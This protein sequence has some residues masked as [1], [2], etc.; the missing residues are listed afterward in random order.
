LVPQVPKA[1]PESQALKVPARSVLP[2]RLDLLVLPEHKASLESRALKV[3][4]R[5]V[6]KVLL[7][8][9]DQ[10]ERKA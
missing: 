10:P 1:L 4:L 6:L 5:S 3:R 9:P 7:A 8:L 2:A